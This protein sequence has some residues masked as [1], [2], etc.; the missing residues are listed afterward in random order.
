MFKTELFVLCAMYCSIAGS[1]YA[2]W[3]TLVNP[4]PFGVDRSIAILVMAVV[5]GERSLWGGIVGAAVLTGMTELLREFIPKILPGTYGDYEIIA[6]GLVLILVLMFLPDGVV[7]IPDRVRR[8][9][10]F[11]KLEGRLVTS[12]KRLRAHEQR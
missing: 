8:T 7:S 5:G 9:S 11:T 6:Y 1:L 3:I 4:S 10:W 2:H 12:W